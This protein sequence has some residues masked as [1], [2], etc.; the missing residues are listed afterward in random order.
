[1]DYIKHPDIDDDAYTLAQ[2]EI[3][4]EKLIA[5]LKQDE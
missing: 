4:I 2:V 5:A 1:L 3:E